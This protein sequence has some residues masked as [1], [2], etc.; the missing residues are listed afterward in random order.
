MFHHRPVNNVEYV[1]E[2]LDGRYVV[3]DAQQGDRCLPTGL[4]TVAE[5]FQRLKDV[6]DAVGILS[7]HWLIQKEDWQ[8]PHQR[9]CEAKSLTLTTGE[10]LAF[11]SNLPLIT[12]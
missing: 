2:S 12:G 7:G 8:P 10:V 6:L 11:V 4:V 5:R 9:A 1:S 3:S